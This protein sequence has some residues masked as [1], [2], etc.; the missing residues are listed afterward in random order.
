M[1]QST[2]SALK[3]ELATYLVKA[4]D[5]TSNVDLLPWWKSTEAE[6]HQQ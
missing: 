6:L 3:G 4:E 5:V 1:S 2:L